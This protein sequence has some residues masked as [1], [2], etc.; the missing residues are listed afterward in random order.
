MSAI[1]CLADLTLESHELYNSLWNC[2]QQAIALNCPQIVSLAQSIPPLDPLLFL[3]E[4]L[5]PHQLHFYWE[6]GKKQTAIAAMGQVLAV[7][8]SGQKRFEEA[9]AFITEHQKKILKITTN[10]QPIN[11]AKFFATFTFF[12][13][14]IQSQSCFSPATVFFP[15]VQI[16]RRQNHYSLV[17]NFSIHPQSN[18]NKILEEINHFQQKVNQICQKSNYWKLSENLPYTSSLETVANYPQNFKKSVKSALNLIA[19]NKLNKIVL[20]HSLDVIS[21]VAFQLIHSLYNLRQKH[22]DCYIF[23]TSNKQDQYFIGASPERLMSLWH[24]QLETDALAGSAPRGQNPQQDV[25]LAQLLLNSEKEKREHQAVSYY[26][27]QQLKKLGITAHSSPLQLLKLANIQHL[28]TPIQ[29]PVP[30]HLH[31][32]KILAQLHPTPAVAGLPSQMACQQ[33]QAY[34]LFNRELYAAPLGWLDM[35]GNSEFIV[36]IR[37]ALITGNQARLYGGA[38]IVAGSDPEKEL[39]EVQLKLQTIL[40]T[41]I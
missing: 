19:K 3:Q 7:H 33:I 37:S 39:A 5:R 35:A 18:L 8:F 1:P 34:E 38:G 14:A 28:W 23:S 22:P 29:A 11:P 24:G 6:N 10:S 4:Y 17:L 26:I 41:L 27:V 25:K 13:Q 20:A 2:Q 12:D 21:P 9:E 36:G 32:L 30:S 16:T 15:Q 31:P 40:N